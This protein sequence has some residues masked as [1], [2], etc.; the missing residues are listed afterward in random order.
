MV[1]SNHV[2]NI[3]GEKIAK[4]RDFRAGFLTGLSSPPLLLLTVLSQL[5]YTLVSDFFVSFL[6]SLHCPSLIITFLGH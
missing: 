2:G 3:P 4:S 6:P 5:G 1:P